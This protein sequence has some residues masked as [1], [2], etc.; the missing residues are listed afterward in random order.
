MCRQLCWAGN[1]ILCIFLLSV[2]FAIFYSLAERNSNIIV[3]IPDTD[4]SWVV[5]FKS[6][7]KKDI[8]NI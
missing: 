3:N 5:I 1:L 6:K 7:G 4:L 8:E 2:L